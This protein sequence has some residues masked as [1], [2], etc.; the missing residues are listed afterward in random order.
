MKMFFPLVVLLLVSSCS[1]PEELDGFDSKIS[2]AYDYKIEPVTGDTF[3]RF[4]M[5]NG[6]T[7]NSDGINDKYFVVGTGFDYDNFQMWIYTREQN[8]VF[9]TDTYNN[10]W[11]GRVQGYSYV[12][13]N[14]VYTVKVEVADT[15][16]EVHHY[17]YDVVLVR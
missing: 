15:M 11:D 14:Q 7:P 10:G 13:P 8:L 3:Y 6:F 2:I 4:Y 5:P 12:S 9:Y 17:N 1:K 16:H